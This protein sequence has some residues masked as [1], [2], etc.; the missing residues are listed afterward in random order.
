MRRAASQAE[1]IIQEERLTGA[2]ATRVRGLVEQAKSRDA[3]GNGA[4]AERLA[5][6][7]LRSARSATGGMLAGVSDDEPTGVAENAAPVQANADG[8]TY[9]P[10]ERE[11]TA[12][13]DAS[14]DGGVSFQ[15]SVPLTPAQAPLAIAEHETSHLRRRSRD[16]T[17]NGQKVMQSI[18][19][20]Y[21]LDPE[22]GEIRI[23]GGRARTIVFPKK[24][25]P[26]LE[27]VRENVRNRLD[28][29]A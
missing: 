22:S 8:D 23:A 17:L 12:Y 3:E 1:R 19:Y 29:E 16:A 18:R 25:L 9:E 11:T 5:R 27:N 2:D 7:A 28:V 15:G 4:D 20:I 14:S 21:R 10:L 6:Q 24:E 26:D 13:S